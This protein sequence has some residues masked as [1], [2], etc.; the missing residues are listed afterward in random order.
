MS[1]VALLAPAALPEHV[2]AAALRN[3]AVPAPAAV[4][5]LTVGPIPKLKAICL[6]LLMLTG[7][8]GASLPFLRVP[9]E[10]TPAATAPPAPPAQAKI[11]PRRDRYGDPL[12]PGAI[13]RL[14]TL[15]FRVDALDI[16]GLAFAPDGKTIAVR[17]NSGVWLLDAVSGKQ[18]RR[19]DSSGALNPG[20]AF[21]PDGKQLIAPCQVAEEDPI[22]H[23]VNFRR[24]VRVW[25]TASGRK[26]RE[27]EVS[28]A[29][30]VGWSADGQPLAAYVDKGELRLRDV[31]TGRE[32]RFAAKDVPP[33]TLCTV[34]KTVLVAFDEKGRVHVWDLANGKERCVLET[35]GPYLRSLALSPNG[36]CLASLTQDNA[37]TYFVR[38]WDTATGVYRIA[39]EQKYIDEVIFSPDGQTLATVGTKEIRFWDVVTRKERGR[40]SIEGWT[41]RTAAFSPDGKTL[42]TAE[43]HSEGAIHLWDVASGTKKPEPEGH[44]KQPGRPSFSPDGKRVATGSA[45]EGTIFIWDP[46]TGKPLVHIHREAWARDYAFSADGRTLYSCLG[47]KLLSLDAATGRELHVLKVEGPER[48]KARQSGLKLYLSDDRT[49]LIVFS[50]R[51]REMLVTGWDVA[52]HKQLFHRRRTEDANWSVV[53]ADA[54]V[55]A[56]PFAGAQDGPKARERIM[57]QGSMLLEDL[58]SGERLMTFPRFEGQ[59]LPLAFSPDGRLLISDTLGPMSPPSPRR[60]GDTLRFWEVLT[61]SELLTMP[62]PT[63]SGFMKAA[64]STEILL[65][66]VRRGKEQHRYKGFDAQVT[67]LTFSPDGRRLV[68]GLSDSTL[69]VWDVPSAPDIAD[70][71]DAD[72]AAKAWADLASTDAPRAFRAR[73]ALAS[74]PAEALPLMKE[75]LRPARPADAQRLRRLLADLESEQFAVREKAQTEL[76][77]LGD[78]AEP[79]LRQALADK[80]SLEMRRRVQAVLDQLRG[81]VTQPELLRSLRAVAVLEDIAT[82]EARRLLETLAAGAAEARQTREAKAALRRLQRRTSAAP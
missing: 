31:A 72:G 37:G 73:G 18:L 19:L 30:W 41:Q 1:A 71:L 38:L 61:A 25:E 33:Y 82:P 9:D 76:Q 35:A 23:V 44:S 51:D 13:A 15:R 26:V 65:W 77:G 29:R 17:G 50:S 48:P 68:S 64:P 79:A 69:L 63:N 6:G 40:S 57:G 5:T 52:T 21:S 45:M 58:A 66:D 32:Q 8:L 42:A 59:T 3:L 28:D 53:S 49:R 11:E 39:T 70:K 78:L 62:V 36:R 55:L 7:G 24:V 2:R 54:R 67:S 47:D 4:N 20:I 75:H 56:A 43:T 81:P 16:R 14:G 10:E 34:G 12:P 60:W 80:P 22:R 27:S 46:A 74:T